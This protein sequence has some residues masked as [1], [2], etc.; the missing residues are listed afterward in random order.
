MFKNIRFALSLLIVPVLIAMGCSAASASEHKASLGQEFTLPVGQSATVPGE[1]MVVK[2]DSVSSDSRTPEGAQTIWAG[3]AK[4]KLEIIYHGSTSA[5]TLTA[6]SSIDGY[7]R[8]SFE[9][10]EISFQ[11]QPYPEVGRQPVDSEY[12]LLMKIDALPLLK[13]GTAGV[14]IIDNRAIVHGN[15]DSSY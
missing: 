14:P 5:V 9:Q 11:L 12:R 4:I 1:N 13:P 3:E 8:D 6:K 2:F 15:G 7:S 10:Y